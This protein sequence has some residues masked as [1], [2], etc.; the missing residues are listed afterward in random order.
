MIT[1]RRPVTVKVIL[2]ENS[3][4]KLHDEFAGSINRIKMELEQLHFQGKKLFADAQ[5]RGPE[6]LKIVKDRLQKEEQLRREKI[7][8]LQSQIDQLALIPLGSELVQGTVESDVAI[9]VGDNWDL[10]MKET[11]I[12][13]RDGIV[14]EIRDFAR[15][16]VARQEEREN[17]E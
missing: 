9:R 5:K 12:V 2:T 10:L 11:E 6:A 14:V 7:E 17:S 15:Q 3:R 4:Q 13:I 8:Q 16:E 1:I